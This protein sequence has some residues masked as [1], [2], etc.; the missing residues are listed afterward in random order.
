[1]KATKWLRDLTE[2]KPESRDLTPVAPM[3]P[4]IASVGET[5]TF[6]PEPDP[7]CVTVKV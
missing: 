6:T 1:M 3:V 2:D 5:D 7:S 4:K